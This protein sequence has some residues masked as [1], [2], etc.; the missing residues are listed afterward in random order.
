MSGKKNERPDKQ[1][2]PYGR[3][4]VWKQV[5]CRSCGGLGWYPQMITWREGGNDCP[6]CDGYGYEYR[7]VEAGLKGVLDG[8]DKMAEGG[9]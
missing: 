9:E 7:E 8:L 5:T 4:K 3:P 1:N 2:K 6:Y